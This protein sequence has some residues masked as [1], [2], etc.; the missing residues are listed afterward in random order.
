MSQ[1]LYKKV[2]IAS[3][4]LMGSV[5][6]SRLMGL[7][8]DMAIA[9]IGG[10][11]GDVDAYQL[12]FLIPEILNHI[13]A[14]GFLSV[15]F[16]PIFSEYLVQDR[17]DEGWRV[18]SVILTCF[19]TLLLLFIA[20]GY[21]F[22]PEIIGIVVRGRDNPEHQTTIVKMTRIIMPAQFFFFTG[23]LFMAVQFA[24]KKFVV[25]ALAPLLYNSGIITGGLFLGPKIGMEGFSWGV[26]A[27][28]FLGNFAMQ[29]WAAKRVGM[30]FNLSFDFFH[31]DLKK[32]VFLTLPLM[33]GLTMMFSMEFFIRFFGAFLPA[34]GIAGLLYGRTILFVLVGLFGQAVGMAAFPYMSHLVAENK[35]AELNQLLNRTLRYLALV[36]PF[37][38]LLM[39]LRYEVVLI[40]LRRGK[41]DADATELTAHVLIFLLIGAFALSAYT[42]VVR[43][44]YAMQNTLFPAIF[45]TIAVLLS[46]PLYG[47]GMMAL[48]ARGIALAVSLSSIF[49]VIVLYTLWNRRTRNTE[50][51]CV[52]RF[53]GGMILF[54]GLLGLFLAY[55]KATVLTGIDATTFWGSLQVCLITGSLFLAVLLTAGYVF[56]IREISELVS[57]S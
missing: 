15:T 52:Y 22:T 33:L 26:L 24:K 9:Y 48:G 30:R 41:F 21:I 40:I 1:Q 36:I 4:I 29:L 23:G 44:Y 16:I 49:Q 11:S 3:I 45:G 54:S 13:L 47:Y 14:S 53:Y 20:I 42:V 39:V 7:P 43:G 5:F 2:G 28:A 6:L 37:S 19:G 51:R 35:L 12:A 31:P 10:A 27:G 17:E 38:V 56:K 8:R 57:L 32:Y 18:F 34:G 55:F 46:L 50:S 25:P